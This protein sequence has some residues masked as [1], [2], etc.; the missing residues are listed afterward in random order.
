[1]TEGSYLTTF[2]SFF[3]S[4]LLVIYSG[5]HLK[6]HFQNKNMEELASGSR[7]LFR[8]HEYLSQI[9]RTHVIKPGIAVYCITQD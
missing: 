7:N 8:K 1:M 5:K 2:I 4:L 6:L 3:P 9:A